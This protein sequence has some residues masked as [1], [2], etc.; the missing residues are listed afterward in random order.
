MALPMIGTMEATLYWSKINNP[1]PKTWAGVASN[2]CMDIRLC[3]KLSEIWNAFR[4]LKPAF[5]CTLEHNG[6]N[7]FKDV[8]CFI[9]PKTIFLVYYWKQGLI[10]SGIYNLY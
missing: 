5:L 4:Y 7:T 9:K 1:R 10:V 6:C 2:N 3:K 8:S